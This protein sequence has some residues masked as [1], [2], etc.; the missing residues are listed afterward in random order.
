M[1]IIKKAAE[2]IENGKVKIASVNPKE[3]IINVGDETVILKKLPGRVMDSCSCRNH[4]RFCNENPRCAHK[5]AAITYMIMRKV[6]W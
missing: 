4:S 6:K 5:M 1:N 2:F 3:I